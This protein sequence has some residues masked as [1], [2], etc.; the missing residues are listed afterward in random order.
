MLRNYYRDSHY[1]KGTTCLII[2]VL[3]APVHS[4]KMKHIALLGLMYLSASLST[5]LD[6]DEIIVNEVRESLSHHSLS[7]R[8]MNATYQE[9]LATLPQECIQYAFTFSDPAMCEEPCGK[10][11][12]SLYKAC[13]V[14]DSDSAEFFDFLCSKNKAGDRC[15]TI[16]NRFEGD[17]PA[18]CNNVTTEFCPEECSLGLKDIGFES[19]CCW[20][21]LL[22][23]TTNQTFIDDTQEDCDLKVPRLC[24]GTFSGRTISAASQLEFVSHVFLVAAML[25]ILFLI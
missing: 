21:S 14:D 2:I 4:G 22:V 10:L 13:S 6:E 16:L 25:T 23:V 3:I 9:I 24:S 20:Y 15:L 19:N 11:L 12:Y 17:F 5:A 18:S 1:K 7:K 8:Q